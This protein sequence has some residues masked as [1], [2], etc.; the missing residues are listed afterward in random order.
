MCN[1]RYNLLINLAVSFMHAICNAS[2][3][4][5]SLMASSDDLINDLCIEQN[6][7]IATSSFSFNY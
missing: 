7:T 3:Y 1:T 6:E 5:I 2:L 4:I